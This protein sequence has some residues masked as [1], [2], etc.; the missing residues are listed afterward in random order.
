MLNPF[1]WENWKIVKY[2]DIISAL[3]EAKVEVNYWSENFIEIYR[4][5]KKNVNKFD[6]K[7]VDYLLKHWLDSFDEK[8]NEDIHLENF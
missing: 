8:W 2:A 7:S 5:L 4:F 1:D 6:I 3:F